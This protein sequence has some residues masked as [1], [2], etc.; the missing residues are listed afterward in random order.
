MRSKAQWIE[1]GEK[2]TN[3]F[4]NL[5]KR[6]YNSSC[7]KKLITEE[8]KEMTDLEEIIQEQKNFYQ[9]LYIHLNN[10]NSLETENKFLNNIDIPKL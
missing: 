9:K 8:G 6:N 3:Y 4:L 2:N 5:E 7:I 10:A 1:E